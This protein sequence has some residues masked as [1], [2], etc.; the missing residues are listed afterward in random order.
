MLFILIRICQLRGVYSSK[1]DAMYSNFRDDNNTD[2]MDDRILETHDA[3]YLSL[4]Q[5]PMEDDEEEKYHP[6]SSSRT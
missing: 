3:P 4:E 6:P 2:L 5:T 1:E